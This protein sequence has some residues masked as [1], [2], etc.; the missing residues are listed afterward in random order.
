MILITPTKNSST[1]KSS[2]S[3]YSSNSASS[4]STMLRRKSIGRYSGIMSGNNSEIRQRVV[5][6]RLHRF[7]SLQNQLSDA[8][9]HITVNTLSNL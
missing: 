6:A 1:S 9:Q 7:K 8:L 2:E 5:S 4:K 3:L